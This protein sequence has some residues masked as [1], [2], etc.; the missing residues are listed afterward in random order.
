MASDSTALGPR[1]QLIL[2]IK[3]IYINELARST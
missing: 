3:V 2:Q 1:L